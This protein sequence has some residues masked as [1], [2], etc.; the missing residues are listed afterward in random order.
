MSLFTKQFFK[1]CV[2]AHQLAFANHLSLAPPIFKDNGFTTTAFMS[3]PGGKVELRCGPAEYHVELFVHDET[4]SIRRTLNELISLPQV[5]EWMESN[6]ASVEG[7]QR[8]E[9]E[10]EYS[11]RLLKEA[12]ARVTEMNWLLRNTTPPPTLD[13]PSN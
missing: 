13:S 1:E 8:I 9:V 2:A 7:R 4:G 12:I 10:V 5:M 6:P 3:A 11:F